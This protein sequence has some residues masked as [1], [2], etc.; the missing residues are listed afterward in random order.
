MARPVCG[1]TGGARLGG[2]SLSFYPIDRLYAAQSQIL[3]G[4]VYI[5]QLNMILN[6]D[7]INTDSGVYILSQNFKIAPEHAE[8]ALKIIIFA[9]ICTM[10]VTAIS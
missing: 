5:L 3:H 1:G 10:R 6:H 8:R 4:M 9:P 2:G 7:C